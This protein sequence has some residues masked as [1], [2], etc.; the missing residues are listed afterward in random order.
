MPN[1]IIPAVK[2]WRPVIN[3]RPRHKRLPYV[4]AIYRTARH[5]GIPRV[6]SFRSAWFMLWYTAPTQQV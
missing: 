6:E 4:W 5:F 2:E 1:E 3:V